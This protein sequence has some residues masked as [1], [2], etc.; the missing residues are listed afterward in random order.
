MTKIEPISLNPDRGWP[1]PELIEVDPIRAAFEKHAAANERFR[2]ARSALGELEDTLRDAEARDRD[3]YADAIERGRRDPGT[4]HADA[5]QLKIAEARRYCDATA[6]V[7]QRTF[8]EL[9]DTVNEHQAAWVEAAEGKYRDA[10]SEYTDAVAA[11]RQ[12]YDDLQR[13][14]ALHRYARGGGHAFGHAPSAQV[15]VHGRDLTVDAMLAAMQGYTP[16]E[17]REATDDETSR[18]PEPGAGPVTTWLH[19]TATAAG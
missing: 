12:K 2:N 1:A 7:R 10:F 14:K 13:A 8:A 16:P 9:R 19:S 3:A 4:Q 6:L 5:H 15:S 18:R 11:M 17:L